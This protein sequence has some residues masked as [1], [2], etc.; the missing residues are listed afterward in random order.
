MICP[1]PLFLESDSESGFI[2]L[3]LISATNECFE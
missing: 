2:S 1:L 3:S